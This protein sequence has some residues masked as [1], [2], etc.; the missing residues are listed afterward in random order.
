MVPRNFEDYPDFPPG[1][2][3][4]AKGRHQEKFESFHSELRSWMLDPEKR[5]KMKNTFAIFL[6]DETVQ[7]LENR[8]LE[9]I[10][11]QFLSEGI[12]ISTGPE[13]PLGKRYSL[14]RG[15]SVKDQELIDGL[16]DL[17]A[18]DLAEIWEVLAAKRKKKKKPN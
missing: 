18:E 2:D 6:G 5:Q 3:R 17:L 14:Y 13:T 16:I 15:N 9:K 11:N 8:I 4:D 7:N 1:A 12:L 10:K